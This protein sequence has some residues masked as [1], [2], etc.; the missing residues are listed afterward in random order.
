[1]TEDMKSKKKRLMGEVNWDD[2]LLSD[3]LRLFDKWALISMIGNLF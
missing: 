1:M 3:K 2:L